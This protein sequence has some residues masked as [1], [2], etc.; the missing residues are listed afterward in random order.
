MGQTP[1]EQRPNGGVGGGGTQGLQPRLRL[2]YLSSWHFH[3][4]NRGSRRCNLDAKGVNATNT[5][6]QSNQIKH[7]INQQ[8]KRSSSLFFAPTHPS[9][10]SE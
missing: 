9:P 1:T 2:L 6:T 10:L 4:G 7:P 3:W 8:S 5:T